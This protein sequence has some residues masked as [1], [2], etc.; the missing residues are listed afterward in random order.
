MRLRSISIFLAGLAVLSVASSAWA[1][2]TATASSTATVSQSPN[3]VHGD[4]APFTAFIGGFSCPPGSP[5][6]TLLGANYLKAT[7]SNTTYK[8]THTNGTNTVDFQLAALRS[9]TPKLSGTTTAYIDGTVVDLLGLTGSIPT[10]INVFIKPRLN[11]PTVA[12][13]AGVYS[14]AFRIKWDWSFCNAIGIGNLCVLGQTDSGS[15]NTDVTVTLTV[16]GV[17][18]TINTATSTTWDDQNGATN[19]KAIPGSKRRMILT[20]GNPDVA[21]QD[22]NVVAVVVATPPN[23]TVA[24]DGDG[25][26][27]ALATFTEGSPSSSLAF[28]YVSSTSSGDDVEFSSD[29]GSTWTFQPTAATQ[30][31]VTHVRLRPRGAM[32][33]KSNFKLSIAYTVK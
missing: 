29:N 31:Q 3:A 11:T 4:A 2:C 7:I 5:V 9:G 12:P 30:G 19:P 21:A 14:G 17:A 13:P 23:T 15:K 27:S 16:G 20:V 1:A 24:L 18:P 32:A 6:L 25:S 8:L 10:S 26:N 33:A 22:N 28:S